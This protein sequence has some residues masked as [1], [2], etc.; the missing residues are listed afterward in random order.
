[1]E[2]NYLQALKDENGTWYLASAVVKGKKITQAIG[3]VEEP[4]DLSSALYQQ[5]P[6]AEILVRGVEC[7]SLMYTLIRDPYNMQKAYWSAAPRG[8]TQISSGC[9]IKNTPEKWV[10]IKG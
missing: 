9:Q 8:I 4:T 7:E 5:I 6:G 2:G 1:M 10:F 3:L